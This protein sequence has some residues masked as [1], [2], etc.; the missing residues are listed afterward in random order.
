MGPFVGATGRDIARR[1]VTTVVGLGAS[2]RRTG[3][4][5]EDPVAPRPEDRAD[6]GTEVDAEM[7]RRPKT[8]SSM[9]RFGPQHTQAASQEKVLKRVAL[10]RYS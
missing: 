9:A 5:V 6:Q 2:G 4:E 8:A 10:I 1:R 3:A 7:Q